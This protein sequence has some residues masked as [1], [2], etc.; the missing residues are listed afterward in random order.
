MNTVLV[1]PDEGAMEFVQLVADNA[2]PKIPF[3]LFE[4]KRENERTVTLKYSEKSQLSQEQ[5]KGKDIVVLD[6][7]V[8]TGSTI[9]KCCNLL[10]TYAPRKIVFAVTHFLSSEEIKQNLADSCIDE[11]IT[12]NTI[13]TILNRDHQGRLRK[14]M[15]VLKINKWIASYLNKYLELGMNFGTHL[16]TEDMSLKNPRFKKRN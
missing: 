5:I 10:K 15:A 6:D 1:A 12:T 11:I 16:Y 4:K 2:E 9:I 3:I 8:R 14:K 7:M 13:P